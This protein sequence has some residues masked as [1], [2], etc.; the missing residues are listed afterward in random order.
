MFGVDD[1]ERALNEA[2]KCGS[3][4]DLVAAIDSALDQHRLDW[5]DL[6]RMERTGSDR[7]RRAVRASAEGMQSGYET[8]MR[9]FLIS[10]HIRFIAQALRGWAAWI[11]WSETDW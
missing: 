3:H 11:S 8:K 2:S 5:M 1:V 6:S 7:L 9:L 10:K 4:L